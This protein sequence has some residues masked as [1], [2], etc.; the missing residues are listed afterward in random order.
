M[1]ILSFLNGNLGLHFRKH[2]DGGMM[3]LALAGIILLTFVLG[4]LFEFLYEIDMF[5]EQDIYQDATSYVFIIDNSGSMS[6]NDPDG[7]RYSAISRIMAEKDDS[8]PYAVYSFSDSVVVDRA[9][10]PISDGNNELGPKYLGG[11]SLKLALTTVLDEYENKFSYEM[12]D[13]PKFLV[14]SDG[15]ATD[16][17]LF[18]K[19]D[20]VLKR[21]AKTNI[22]VSTVGLGNPDEALM[23]R[24]ADET[25]GVYINVDDVDSLE[26]SMK[27]AITKYGED[28]YARTLYTRRSVPR[29]NFVYAIMRILFTS[30]L[31]ILMSLAMLFATGKSEDSSMIIGSSLITGAIAG[32]LMESGI[33][34]LGIA[35][36]ENQT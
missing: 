13:A 30:I 5:S 16:I 1:V 12:G 21:Y 7:L 14:L 26:D 18:R 17:G 9:I 33:N 8:F 4:L 27:Q 25:G 31:G 10:A 20:P 6:G 3:T 11:T 23:Q 29:L 34:L 35:P 32:I 22:S 2:K 15:Y 28:K 36:A 24:I 19:I